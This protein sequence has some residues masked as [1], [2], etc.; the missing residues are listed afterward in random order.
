[1]K[2]DTA[3]VEKSR[4]DF[5]VHIY[6]VLLQLKSGNTISGGVKKNFTGV[7]CHKGFETLS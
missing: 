5:K 2:M 6:K 7:Y 3:F 4:K 1:M